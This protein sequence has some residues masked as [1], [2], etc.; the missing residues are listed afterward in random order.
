MMIFLDTE[1][2]G[3]HGVMVLLQYA[4]DDGEIKLHDIWK[5]KIE[6]TLELLEWIANQEVCMFNAAYDW[7]HISKLYTT[8]SLFPDHSVIPIEHI[9]ELAILEEQARFLDI[10]IKPKACCDIMLH[11]QKGSFQ[12]L[13]SRGAIRVKR[14]PSQLVEKVK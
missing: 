7:F 14:I 10:C 1:T 13:M 5:E 3:F 6:D 4:K 8:F 2:C 11:A 12:S 9:D